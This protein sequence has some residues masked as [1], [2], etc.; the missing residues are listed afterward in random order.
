MEAIVSSD[1]C[2]RR[3]QKRGVAASA[4]R[5]TPEAATGTGLPLRAERGSL[6]ETSPWRTKQER[7]GAAPRF[8]DWP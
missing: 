7:A 5:I 4:R 1:D 6:R 3:L 8:W 2:R